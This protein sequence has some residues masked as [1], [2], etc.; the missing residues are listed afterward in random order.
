MNAFDCLSAQCPLLGPHI[1]EASAGTGK[2]F[3]IEH[4][5]V[6]LLLSGELEL[7]QILT[8]TFTRA[9][10]RELKAR[11]KSNLDKAISF[12]Q[13]GDSPWDYLASIENPSRAIRILSDAKGLFDRSQI[14]TIHGFCHRM[15]KEFA[16]EA[17]LGFSL[18]HPDQKNSIPKRVWRAALQFLEEEIDPRLLSVE[19]VGLLLK[20]YDSLEMLAE[21]LFQRGEIVESSFASSWENYRS[22][23]ASW[24]D[25]SIEEA[26]LLEDFQTIA[27][28]YKATVKGDFRRQV[29]SLALSFLSPDDPIHFRNLL[30]E[31][32][33]LFDYLDPS[34]QKIKIVLPGPLHYPLF[35]SWAAR[36]I[37]PCIQEAVKEKNILSILRSAWQK[38][39]DSSFL[40]E[41]WLD[42]DAILNRMEKAVG[43]ERFALRVRNK[44][45][46]VIVDEFQDTDPIQWNIFRLLFLDQ[47]K[48]L[49]AL[50]L[51]GD[52]KQSIYRFRK[53]DVYTY[54]EARTFL[55]DNA[56]YRLDTN[57]RSSKKIISAL[58]RLFSRH[59]LPL[60][61][62]KQTIPSLPVL[63]GSDFTA[64]FED[65]KGAIH[66][67]IAKSPRDL[68]EETFLPYAISQIENLAL[69]AVPW[70]SFAILVKDRHQA[71]AAL[72]LCQARSI[73]AIAK[74]HM[75]LGKTF[76]FESLLELFEAIASPK[77]L[78]KQRRV[79]LGP[80]QSFSFNGEKTFLEETGL[81]PFFRKLTIDVSDAEFDKDFRQ[82][83]EE[84]LIWEGLEGFSF[85]GLF[86]F[87]D[88]M[89]MGD[90]S[91]GGQRRVQ[92]DANAVQILTLHI[93]KGLEFEVVFALG[94]ASRTPQVEEAEE[95]DA[96]KLR[97]L[98]VAMTRAKLRLYVPIIFSDKAA[99]SGSLSPIELFMQT[100]EA[101]EGPLLPFLQKLS[102]EENIT[103][104]MLNTP[105]ELSAIKMS[106]ASKNRQKEILIAPPIQ[107]SFL[108]SFTSLA[109][110]HAGVDNEP[111]LPLPPAADFTSHTLPRGK[112]TGILIHQ[113]FEHLFSSYDPL[114]R[115]RSAVEVLVREQIRGSPLFPW[116][117]AIVEMIWKTLTRPLE[118]GDKKFS[119]IDIASQNLQVEMEFLFAS[120]PDYVKGFIDLIFYFENKYYIVDWKTNWLGPDEA[121]YFCL[122]EAMTAHDYWLQAA[123]YAEAFRRHVKQ[124]DMRPFE[125]IFG[126]A[127]YLFVRGAGLCHF[128]PDFTL[129]ER[130]LHGI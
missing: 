99:P 101:Q 59:W 32:G 64:S 119:L 92:A 66:F 118:A 10:A 79:R 80:F 72:E 83:M 65:E 14:F 108:L 91:S 110:T 11:I 77:D 81:I 58:N 82:I 42:P 127:L 120:P 57:F 3:S 124:F 55:G 25:S 54:F 12:L 16:F 121:S 41:E 5:F 96:E 98:Y 33:S 30:G 17:N 53:A 123:L 94:L 84:L 28:N 8:V 43:K 13:K 129:I 44:Y 122:K 90:T 97:Q 20:K 50:Y 103:L 109:Q 73:P 112:E 70:G 74:S 63:A 34:N 114:W 7:E 128:M 69:R 71:R 76:A 113:I 2:T 36:R 62:L 6:R 68:F 102:Q 86:R 111:S 60:P 105:F 104:D 100:L 24:G 95:L 46:A 4:I 21:S 126:G 19:Q 88:A 67:M 51:V 27:P 48:P 1:L 56:L 107:P 15:L 35:F 75:P 115:D 116:E 78:A 29:S 87:L 49:D 45:K 18:P 40:E 9:A 38:K 61:Q 47:P 52:P 26:Q 31:K 125:E 23:L 93:S 117:Q 89:E 106:T 37:A 22:G 39:L 130:A 85:Q